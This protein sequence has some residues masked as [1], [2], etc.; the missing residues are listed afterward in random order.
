MDCVGTLHAQ[1]FF[2]R[3]GAFLG[4]EPVATNVAAKITG[5][6]VDEMTAGLRQALGKG[7]EHAVAQL[8]AT[9]GFLADV[10]VKIP[11]PDDLRR[12]EQG[13]RDLGQGA[14]A[15]QF[16]T[17]MNRA[18]EQAVPVAASVLG[19]AVRQM[20]VADAQAILQGPKDAATAYFRRVGQTNLYVKFLPIVHDATASVGVT[21]AYKGMAGKAS[22]LSSFLGSDDLDLDGYV[23]RKALDGL[24]IKIAD[25]EKRIRE[26]PLARTTDLLKKVFGA[27]APK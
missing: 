2:D 16:V 21:A 25:E 11:V 22:F 8:G 17:A 12:I 7:V 5:L 23:T 15:D 9:N 24:F 14:L 3:I 10:A 4:A 27:V 20:T 1:G 6:S 19:D 26:N 18:A 13:V